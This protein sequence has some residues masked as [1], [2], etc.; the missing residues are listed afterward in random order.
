MDIEQCIAE[1]R[2]PSQLLDDKYRYFSDNGIKDRVAHLAAKN[3]P[4][5]GQTSVSTLEPS[6]R[7]PSGWDKYYF[8]S[9]PAD[10]SV[11][12]TA[13]RGR[14]RP[15]ATGPQTFQT[16]AF[17]PE[18]MARERKRA[19]GLGGR[20]SYGEFFSQF[21][22]SGTVNHGRPDEKGP[23]PLTTYDR[24]SSGSSGALAKSASDSFLQR[25]S[26][27]MAAHSLLG[28]TENRNRLG[29]HWPPPTK[30]RP[31]SLKTRKAYFQGPHRTFVDLYSTDRPAATS[32]NYHI[33][34][35]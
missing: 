7:A 5:L 34:N 26:P 33:T 24:P 6:G 1:G 2:L 4:N 31:D 35:F 11:H 29:P 16:E 21:Q 3:N 19:D 10:G 9:V 22:R 18:Q 17:T 13:R 27:Q 25:S 14:S 20:T 12:V 15:A 30:E 8:F 32:T 28:T 23:H